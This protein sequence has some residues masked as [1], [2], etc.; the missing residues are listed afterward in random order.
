MS[1]VLSL[2]YFLIGLVLA[3]YGFNLVLTTWLYWR[4]RNETIE[5]PKLTDYPRVTIQL[6]M[7]NELYVAERL[8][9]AAAVIEWQPDRLQIQVLDDSDDETITLAQARVDYWRKRGVDIGYHRRTDRSG[10][11]A[12]ALAAGLKEATGE[13][14]AVFDADFVP[15]PDFLQ[16]TIPHF[17]SQANV[18]MVQTRWGHLNTTYSVLTQAEALALDGHFVVEQTARS[19]NGLFFNFNGTAGVWRR[20]CID[21]AGGWQGDTLSEDLDLSYRAQML[22]WKF[23][24]LPD[25]V[26][27]AELP[28]Q[29]HAFKRQ[30]FRWAKGSTQV[31]LKL[32]PRVLTDSTLPL[33]KRIEGFL[34][35]SGYLMNPLVVFALLVLVPLMA[36]NAQTPDVMFYFTFAMLG[37]IVLYGISQRALYPK[38]WLKHFR[39]FGVLLLIGTGIALNNS[40]AV[41]EA[42]TRRGNTFRRTPKFCVEREE[43]AWSAKQY[44]LPLGWEVVGEWFL[45]LYAAVG[46]GVAWSH[47]LYW[48]LPYMILYMLSFAFVGGLSLWHAGNFRF[49]ISRE[50]FKLNY[51]NRTVD[52]G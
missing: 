13:Y 21:Q 17:F 32:G 14:I 10:F 46:V 36:V 50:A 34:H 26:S 29:I 51:E 9:D 2:V 6:P 44:V 25:V 12:G 5:T 52:S 33:F 3:I 23:L 28:P 8:I 18:G 39:Y 22:G 7:Y 4:K 19:R 11:K 30:Q 20:V 45:S 35:L 49:Q 48:T 38:D 15:S 16:R 31:L 1:L 37:P 41:I 27:P 42:I 47:H 24:F 43:D 40:I